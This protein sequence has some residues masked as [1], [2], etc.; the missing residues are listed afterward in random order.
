M[1]NRNNLVFLGFLCALSIGGAALVYQATARIGPGVAGDGTM[2]LS[3]AANLLKGRGFIDL[4]G[5]ALL[6]WPPLYPA[7][8]AFISR[9]TGAD[10]LV[11]ARYINIVTFGLIVF[12]S[13][14]LL[15]K[16]YPDRMLFAYIV[17]AVTATSLGLLDTCSSILSDP[18]FLLFVVLFLLAI[19][20]FIADPKPMHL[21]EMGFIAFMASMERYAGLALVL[22]GA[23][24]LIRFYWKDRA[25]GLFK[26]ALFSLSGLP[27]VLW[28]IFH[29]YPVSG[30][31]FGS[32]YPANIPGNSYI[33]VQKILY[34]FF[35]YAV[36][37]IATPFGLLIAI[38]LV[39]V[40]LNRSSNWKRWFQK[41]VSQSNLANS[42]LIVVYLGVL[43]FYSSYVETNDLGFQR[44]HIILL[45]P[46]MIVFFITYDELIP[47]HGK[48]SAT[49][50][51]DGILMI[52][53]MI[54]LIYP[55]S[56]IQAYEQGIQVS[57]EIEN[58]SFNFANI[59]ES[60]FLK[61]AENLS[62][63]QQIYSNYEPAAWFYLRRDIL[64]IP[65]VDPKSRQFNSDSL[66][67]FRDLIH[68]SGGGYLV[69]FATINYRDNIPSLNQ[70]KQTVKMEPVF[71][72]D[73]GD[74]YHISPAAP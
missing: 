21:F 31:L 18:V 5:N 65:R 33:T 35:P 51:K 63:S 10:I 32:Y 36:I 37:K 39:L 68:S 13:G 29:N 38:V 72:S 17:S 7:L 4:Y 44:F 43:I 64:S 48:T 67:K 14:I 1:E 15:Q 66:A 62:A 20:S 57:G 55:L 40:L 6:Q 22:T 16:M 70:L 34:W 3:V 24:F 71:T 28:G 11:A 9:L 56:A 26:S 27:V 74:I 8:I 60:D 47:P 53:F 58:N 41:L 45:I 12:I 30:R 49:R 73:V 2:Y 61:A 54:W 23:V 25:H 59:R 50:I 42:I 19:Q 69:W 52:V 46:L